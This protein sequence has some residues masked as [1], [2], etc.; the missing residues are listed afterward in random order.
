M[1]NLKK[2]QICYS[3]EPT[4]L[5]DSFHYNCY[6]CVTCI[7]EW[8]ITKVQLI[9][10]D[11]DSQIPCHMFSCK[12]TIPIKI[13]YKSLPQNCQEKI[14]IALFQIY[15]IKQQDIRKCPNQNCPY[16]GIMNMSTCTDP[17]ECS[18]CGTTWREYNH[19]AWASKGLLEKCKKVRDKKNEFF[20]ELR[21][22]IFAK[23]CPNCKAWIEKEEGC[24]HVTC[25]K[26]RCDFCWVCFEE[27]PDH[28]YDYHFIIRPLKALLLFI[29]IAFPFAFLL[30]QI[31]P[32]RFLADWT[33]MPVYGY[34]RGIFV[35]VWSCFSVMFWWLYSFSG[36]F[37][38]F[39]FGTFY[40]GGLLLNGNLNIQKKFGCFVISAV[41]W[42]MAYIFEVGW[43]I[44]KIALLVSSLTFIGNLIF[45]GI[46]KIQNKRAS[47]S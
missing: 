13:I 30:Y 46:N 18:L 2:C 41:C 26:C 19:L 3:N 31:P 33:I 28:N 14:N 35:F 37:L 17:F 42:S 7:T 1:K 45:W 47:V 5:D 40:T 24:E 4:N 44:A 11:I 36:K 43:S 27:T 20:S 10:G 23:K 29:V 34:F 15:L 38:L 16:A 32:L 25:S 9:K 39:L 12:R 21:K 6:A 22:R 8:I